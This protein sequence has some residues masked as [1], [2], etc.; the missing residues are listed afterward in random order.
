MSTI[1]KV[2]NTD[3]VLAVVSP[4]KFAQTTF[5]AVKSLVKRGY[6]GI[7]ITANKASNILQEELRKNKLKTDKIYYIDAISSLIGKP[8]KAKNTVCAESPQSLTEISIAVTNILPVLKGKKF[9]I[10]DSI[11]TLLMYNDVLTVARFVHFLVGRMR[12][13]KMIGII[14]AVKKQMPEQMKAQISQFVDRIIDI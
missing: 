14:F 2:K 9:I 6:S 8:K 5:E 11:S 12:E 13:W 7:Y 3:V 1:S 10:L 4:E